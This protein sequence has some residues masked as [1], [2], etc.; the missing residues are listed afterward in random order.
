MSDPI[1]LGLTFFLVQKKGCCKAL[2]VANAF[3]IA[4]SNQLPQKL[5]KEYFFKN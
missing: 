4:K 3:D 2:W 1:K 5:N